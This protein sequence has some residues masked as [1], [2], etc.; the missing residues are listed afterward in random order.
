MDD[1]AEERGRWGTRSF[2]SPWAHWLYWSLAAESRSGFRRRAAKERPVH[3]GE[4]GKKPE[5]SSPFI[6]SDSRDDT[7]RSL[8]QHRRQHP[9]RAVRPPSSSCRRFLR[10]GQYLSSDSFVIRHKRTK[11]HPSRAEIS[12]FVLLC[13]SYCISFFPPSPVGSW[14][15]LESLRS[16][17]PVMC[18]VI[19]GRR[20]PIFS[21]PFHAS[22]RV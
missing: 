7:G 21:I 2:Q 11:I 8:H 20:C 13:L 22:C 3:S 15:F 10:L 1:E 5:S 19:Q 18:V 4:R 16:R 6:Q 9:R 14:M 12:R 17:S